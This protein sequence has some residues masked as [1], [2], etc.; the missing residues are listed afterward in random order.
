MRLYLLECHDG[1]D[2]N[3]RGWSSCVVAAESERDAVAIHP[4]MR[5][6][7]VDG[8][9]RRKGW[10][11]EWLP[12]EDPSGWAKNPYGVNTRM[13]GTAVGSIPE[14][15]VVCRSY[16]APAQGAGEEGPDAA[17]GQEA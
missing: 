17:P 1:Y 15:S 14:M 3:Y 16:S 10:N 9:W 11:G 4:N 5:D 7:W 2:E 12:S 6:F 8:A 13:I